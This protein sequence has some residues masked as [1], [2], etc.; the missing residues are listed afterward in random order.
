[1]M[2]PQLSSPWPS[3]HADYAVLLCDLLC[4]VLLTLYSWIQIGDLEHLSACFHWHS[5]TG[6]VYCRVFKKKCNPWWLHV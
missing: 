3:Y 4:A 5:K 2:I 1:M 6:R